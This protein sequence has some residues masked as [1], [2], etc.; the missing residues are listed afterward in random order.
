MTLPV[1]RVADQRAIARRTRGINAL[2]QK[3]RTIAPWLQDTDLP[4]LRGFAELEWLARRVFA[5]LK[6]EG[7][8]SP[9]TNDAK[10]LLSEYRSLRT[11]QAALAS[12]LGL[13][14]VAR[15]ALVSG[16]KE[17]GFDLLN[18]IAEHDREEV[19]VQDNVKDNNEDVKD[20]N[21]DNET[22]P[23]D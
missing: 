17:G 10:K 11:A 4:V 13:T 23:E 18:A 9:K 15:K 7:I 2:M 19:V 21:E 12:Q 20:N 3:L 8:L 14:P 16:G 5:L 1:T 22:K 6:D